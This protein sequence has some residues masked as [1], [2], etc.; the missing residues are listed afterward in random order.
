MGREGGY[1]QHSGRENQA[2]F[3]LFTCAYREGQELAKTCPNRRPI[4]CLCAVKKVKSVY[5][6]LCVNMIHAEVRTG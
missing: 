6:L 4:S 2:S 1:F 3:G 5:T